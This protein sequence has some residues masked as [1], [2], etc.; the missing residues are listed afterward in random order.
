[1]QTYSCLLGPSGVLRRTRFGLNIR[2]VAFIACDRLCPN[3][4]PFPQVLHLAMSDKPQ[5]ID[6]WST[7]RA[8]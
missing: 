6:D 4:G 8:V 7:Q 3:C 5:R 2:L 1:M